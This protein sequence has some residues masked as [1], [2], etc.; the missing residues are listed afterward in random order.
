[1]KKLA[2]LLLL[3]AGCLSGTTRTRV[4]EAPDPEIGDLRAAVPRLSLLEA[5]HYR[6]T[7]T[8]SDR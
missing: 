8:E 2:V 7:V 1:V 5:L 4:V 6:A 3:C